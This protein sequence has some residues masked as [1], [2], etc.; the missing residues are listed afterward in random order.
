[1]NGIK[2]II[3]A[4]LCIACNQ[5]NSDDTLVVIE[6]L[7]DLVAVNT[8][9]IDNVIACASGSETDNEFVAYV[10]PRPGASDLRF[11]E[12][13][14]VMVDKN[15]Y[16]QYV[17][18]IEESEDLFN[19]FLKKFTAQS[20]TE[21]WVIITF[22][23]EGELHLSNPIR[24]KHQ[25]QNTIFTDQVTIN[26]SQEGMP[27]FSWSAIVSELDAIYFQVVSD[28]SNE[29]LS[30]TYTFEDMFRYYKLDNVVLNVTPDTPP[31]LEKEQSYEFLLMA[32]SE[33]N[34]V[35]S[36]VTRSFVAQ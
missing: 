15:D 25:T 16:E 2:Y 8:V 27:L 21:K 17:P 36:F 4:F 24:I 32:V 30:G 5:D 12:T 31:A 10:Y 34:W 19:G 33:D 35:N 14:D 28:S 20:Q 6:T 13:T 29:F 18:G 1:M 3:L 22:K 9:Q 23:E 26:Q 11:F 7:A